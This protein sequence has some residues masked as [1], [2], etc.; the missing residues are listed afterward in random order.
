MRITDRKKDLIKTS[1]GKYIA[2]SLIESKL[3]ALCPILANVIVHA[4]G[5]NYATALVTL[6]PDVTAGVAEAE[7]IAGGPDAWATDPKI[8]KI[9]RDALVV[10]NSGLNRWETVKDVR[11][12]PRD[13]SVDDGELTP[14]LKIKRKVV[15]TKYAELLESMYGK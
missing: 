10:L 2:P 13:L 7:G 9:V 15:E 14:S 5:R 8:E 11:I 1:G 6:D 12:L 4:N 3:K